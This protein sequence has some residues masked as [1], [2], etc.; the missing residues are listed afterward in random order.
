LF[1]AQN[2]KFSTDPKNSRLW[3]A[4]PGFLRVYFKNFFVSLLSPGAPP[5]P[6]GK[7][8]VIFEHKYFSEIYLQKEVS[9]IYR[10]GLLTLDSRL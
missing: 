8:R 9:A 2:E 6:F 5:L 4:A 7:G 1:S 10:N 3:I